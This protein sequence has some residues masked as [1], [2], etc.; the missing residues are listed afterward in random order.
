M[1]SKIVAPAESNAT[2]E[3]TVSADPTINSTTAPPLV[4]SK[5]QE[6]RMEMRQS[7]LNSKQDLN[8]MMMMLNK[9][10][11]NA[12]AASNDL[13]KQMENNS[14]SSAVNSKIKMA[15][16]SDRKSHHHDHN[17]HSNHHH[18]HHHSRHGGHSDKHGGSDRSHKQQPLHCRYQESFDSMR[19]LHHG[20]KSAEKEIYM[21][22]ADD[23]FN[24]SN[25]P[26]ANDDELSCTIRMD[27][28]REQERRAQK[29]NYL[30]LISILCMLL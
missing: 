7:F 8:D 23:E 1:R 16:S 3:T 26:V 9:D 21:K 11:A 10:L 28:E 25:T 17:L 24:N 6:A 2:L 5:K 30:F 19:P 29:S 18:H 15:S 12:G 22:M 14:L 13:K 27:E 20:V 4:L